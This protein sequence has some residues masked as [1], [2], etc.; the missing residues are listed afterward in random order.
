MKL[1]Y[2]SFMDIQFHSIVNPEVPDV[3]IENLSGNVLICRGW[4]LDSIRGHLIDYSDQIWRVWSLHWCLSSVTEEY[5]CAWSEVRNSNGQLIGKHWYSLFLF[6]KE[7]KLWVIGVLGARWCRQKFQPQDW[8]VS[9]FSSCLVCCSIFPKI[10][11]KKNFWPKK[12]KKNRFW[13][14]LFSPA[15][16]Q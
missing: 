6:P 2:D 3:L 4:W 12:K 9:V 13:G 1:L 14:H 11:N 10:N 15:Q 7:E 16:Q 8:I 5:W